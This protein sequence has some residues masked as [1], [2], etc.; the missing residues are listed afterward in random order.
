M[1][2]RV[3]HIF[4]NNRRLWFWPRQLAQNHP[5][6]SPIGAW[7]IFRRGII[8][9]PL[10]IFPLKLFAKYRNLPVYRAFANRLSSLTPRK[11]QKK[12]SHDE[13]MYTVITYLSK[14]SS[15]NPTSRVTYRVYWPAY[16]NWG[17]GV[18]WS[19]IFEITNSR[20]TSALER[21]LIAFFFSVR[22]WHLLGGKCWS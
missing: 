12:L 10:H 8:R 7:G 11:Q 20:T 3:G 15:C 5:S 9:I 14:V 1:T 21:A 2:L 6:A 13:T 17:A 22:D 4:L 16:S 19:W 18:F